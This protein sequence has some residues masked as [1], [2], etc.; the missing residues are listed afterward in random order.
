MCTGDR[1]NLLLVVRPLL[2]AH[3]VHIIDEIGRDAVNSL[4]KSFE[5]HHNLLR[6]PEP[7]L[8][9]RHFF[10]RFEMGV[11][12]KHVS[13]RIRVHFLVIS[14]ADTP[15]DIGNCALAGVN[16]AFGDVL[17]KTCVLLGR[18]NYRSSGLPMQ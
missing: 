9:H 12:T 1:T 7:L 15:D 10:A 8:L 18:D 5:I 13:D 17:K 2:V 14:F 11:S 3:F 4:S 6:R 16:I